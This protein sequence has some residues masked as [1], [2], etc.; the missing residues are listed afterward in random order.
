MTFTVHVGD[1][2]TVLRTLPDASVHACVTS[3]PYFR[4][5][6]YG[7]PGQIGRESSPEAFVEALVAVFVEVRRVLRHDGVLWLNIGDSHAGQ[8]GG[9]QGKNGQRA[10]HDRHTER[11][12]SKTG[13]GLKPKDLIGIPWMLAF[14]LRASGW[15]L[16]QRCVWH[17]PNNKPENVSD[18]PHTDCEDVFL[19]SNSSHYFYDD[20]AVRV[21]ATGRRP[22]NV[23]R[24]KGVEDRP[25]ELRTRGGLHMVQAEG[26]R[27]LR[28]VWSVPTQ[29]LEEAHF[30]AFPEKLALIC[31]LSGT[32]AHGCCARCGSPWRRIVEKGEPLREQQ[33]ACG[34]DANGEYHGAAS[35]V[36]AGT[37]AQDASALKA[38]ILAGMRERRTV[39]WRPTCACGADVA[40]CTV[41]D[42]FA[43]SGTTG[44]VA[45]QTGRRFVGIEL[46]P[47]YAA[48]ARRR[49]C[50]VA[51]LF[52]SPA[53]AGGDA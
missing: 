32:S 9:A 19:L 35:K 38:R 1:A 31:V 10:A 39:G 46:N 44:V 33:I 30:A 18:R 51:P 43:G 4:L 52:V 6:D 41:L 27:H 42:P 53:L 13:D 20:E 15:W 45:V 5:R 48:I 29:P 36:F 7:H 16:R 37:G 47:T 14:A 21:P 12:V 25:V 3:P 8:G 24:S 49:I 11:M 40:P 28:S 2:L 50:G 23:G 34:A 26:T 17:K 22:G